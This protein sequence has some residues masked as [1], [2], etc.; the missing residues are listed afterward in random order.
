MPAVLTPPLIAIVGPPNAGKTSLFNALT[1]TGSQ[2]VN[3]P[4]ATVE[5]ALGTARKAWGVPLRIADTPG[6]YSLSPKSPEEQVTFQVLF[7]NAIEKPNV[8][9]VVLDGTQLSR[10]I[11]LAR[12]VIETGYRVVLAITMHDL[13][14]KEG[15]QLDPKLLSKELGTQA[16]LI[17]ATQPESLRELVRETARLAA[18][19]P[20]T[21]IEPAAWSANR[22]TTELQ[23]AARTQEK[24]V[25]KAPN[26]AANPRSL[27]AETRKLDA[28]FLHPVWGLAIFTV[29]M[30]ALFTSIFS[31]A[32][33]A[34]DFISES[35]EKFAAL[36]L[37]FAPHSLW[38]DF[39]A[40]GIVLSLGAILT[41]V[42]QIM[43]LFLGITLL[44]DS[45]YLARAATL[46][47]RPLTRLGLNGRSFVP[48]LSGY[49]CAIPAMLAARTIPSKKER[50]LTLWVIPLM[51]C[52]ARLP[53]YSLLLAFLFWEQP[54]WKPGLA[55][56]G[57]YLLSLIV[58]A[59][60]AAVVNRWLP[61]EEC[62]FFLMELPLYRRP[63]LSGV[64]KT[65]AMRTQSYLKK[66]GP[67]IFVFATALW[68]L[69]TFPNYRAT[70]PS[71]KLHSSY[72]AQ[73]GRWINPWMEPMGGDWRTGVSL[74]SA[75]AAREVFVS[76]LGLVLQVSET[77]EEKREVSLL[78]SMQTVKRS[79]GTPL[80]T[81]AST[82]GL[83]L[84]VL[85]ALQC[86]STVAVARREFGGWKMP[87]LQ[88]V[89]FN[90]LAYAVAV[91]AVQGLHLLGVQ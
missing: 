25:T 41:F 32:A 61:R 79:D 37:E 91:L 17:N 11:P 28:V 16:F 48:L 43:I 34:M 35:F 12:Q 78:Q 1:G 5:Y 75:F 84:F 63:S 18:Q 88:L 23:W 55:L 57:I 6:T 74:I 80:F 24:V 89:S 53:V 62:S 10:H 4:G 64:F 22:L 72:A 71:E 46:I 29:I 69:T 58:G 36:I 7:G 38:A 20:S 9:I 87:L 49:A 86:M 30:A 21:V 2:P 45:G 52:S 66:A 77:D 47:D 3:Y 50:W 19:P 54:A 83:I 85:I 81:T 14:A 15:T 44:E 33:P 70:D 27:T 40:G 39:L 65:V 51:S 60:S 42:P 59:V 82:A 56:A 31:L 68:A 67:A 26:L 76:S 13:L 8:V 90:L 73:A